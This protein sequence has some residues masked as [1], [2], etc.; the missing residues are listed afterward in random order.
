[1]SPGLKE[2]ALTLTLEV[3]VL[4]NPWILVKGPWVW[5]DKYKPEKPQELFFK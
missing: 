4:I 5:L 2:S 3:L 1:M